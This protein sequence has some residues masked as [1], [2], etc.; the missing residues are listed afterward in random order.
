M[1]HTIRLRKSQFFSASKISI[2]TNLNQKNINIFL[3]NLLKAGFA[4]MTFL[5]KFFYFIPA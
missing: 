3:I 2:I 5:N 4:S 1:D